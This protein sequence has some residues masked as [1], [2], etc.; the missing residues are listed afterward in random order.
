MLETLAAAGT[1]GRA[2]GWRRWI[3]AGT[4]FGC[5]SWDW[6]T[7]AE[8]ALASTFKSEKS[9]EVSSA[10][11]RNSEVSRVARLQNSNPTT[12]KITLRRILESDNTRELYRKWMLNSTAMR[13]R[14]EITTD[15]RNWHGSA[16]LG[17]FS[18]SGRCTRRFLESDLRDNISNY[19]LIVTFSSC[20]PGALVAAL[21]VL[22]REW[23]KFFRR[24]AHYVA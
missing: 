11:L 8:H 6:W 2:F 24:Q 20:K 7:I 10:S 3:G 14:A 1:S 15:E 17:K 13:R 23:C 22:T 16:R 5:D 21:V 19:L 9:L 12:T 4:A 18:G